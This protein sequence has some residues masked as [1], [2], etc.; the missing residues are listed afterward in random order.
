MW[1]KTSKNHIPTKALKAGE[2]VDGEDGDDK[3]AAGPL[4][5]VVQLPDAE[6]GL[7]PC[8]FGIVPCAHRLLKI[9]VIDDI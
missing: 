8:S 1:V 6:R 3:M 4:H 7:V 9:N 5:Y 2:D